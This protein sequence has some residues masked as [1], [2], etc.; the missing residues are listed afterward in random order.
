MKLSL[1]EKSAPFQGSVE[2]EV[3][4]T[5]REGA[6]IVRTRVD[7]GGVGGGRREENDGRVA[8]GGN[9]LV[10]EDAAGGGRQNDP[11]LEDGVIAQDVASLKGE[12]GNDGEDPQDEGEDGH[13]PMSSRSAQGSIVRGRA[14]AAAATSAR[15]KG[16]P[17]IAAGTG[18]TI[19]ASKAAGAREEEGDMAEKGEQEE[20]DGGRS[21]KEGA[22]AWWRRGEGGC[23]AVRGRRGREEGG[24]KVDML[25]KG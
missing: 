11:A 21:A 3:D 7:L 25:R 13:S 12:L 4:A 16:L 18:G 5:G 10:E 8:E 2:V 6:L 17:S 19:A 23:R 9:V 22:L 15:L 1:R 14:M 24:E 20:E